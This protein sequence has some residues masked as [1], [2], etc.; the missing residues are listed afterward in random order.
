MSIDLNGMTFFVSST[1]GVG[2]VG[3][4]TRLVFSQIGERVIARYA[5]GDVTRGCLVGRWSGEQ[6][7]F[8]YA[9][10]EKDS[11]IH[12]GHSVCD[13]LR[14]EQGRTRILEHFTWTTRPGSGTN[15]FDEVESAPRE[16]LSLTD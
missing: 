4:D 9:Q 5:G 7:I 3:S 13:V 16:P 11:A 8:R 6:L 12:G 2:V 15:V 10:R 14:V 1:A